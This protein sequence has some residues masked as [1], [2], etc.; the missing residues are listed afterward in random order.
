MEQPLPVYSPGC[1]TSL[2]N[3][4]ANED[5]GSEPVKRQKT[6]LK[7]LFST[8]IMSASI[9]CIVFHLM[10]MLLH[11][12][13]KIIYVAGILGIIVSIVV[14]SRQMLLARID[15][16]RAVHNKVREEVNRLQEEN[17]DLHRNVDELQVKVEHVQNI[18]QQLSQIAQS[19]NSTVNKLMIL[20]KENGV[21]VKKQ[22]DVIKASFAEQL[23]TTVLLTDRNN[24]MKIT[25]REANLLVMRLRN[26]QGIKLNENELRASLRRSNG[27]ISAIMDIVHNLEKQNNQNDEE[28][29]VEIDVDAFVRSYKKQ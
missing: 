27:S 26:Q 25:E 2:D 17:N 9:G 14:I 18:E 13:G 10:S 6:G 23:F 29:I 22:S 16:L 21:V 11:R 8:V 15:T 4:L 20:V 28:K 12:D 5:D 3:S 1:I 19:Q 7:H 24:D